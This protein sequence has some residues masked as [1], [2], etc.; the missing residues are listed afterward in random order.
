MD[1]KKGWKLESCKA[2]NG[3]TIKTRLKSLPRQPGQLRGRDEIERKT[4][5]YRPRV[6][7]YRGEDAAGCLLGCRLRL[8]LSPALPFHNS[9]ALRLVGRRTGQFK[10]E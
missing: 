4:R 6:K 10:Q 8:L 7:S 3:W 1:L 2:S 5:F 9:N